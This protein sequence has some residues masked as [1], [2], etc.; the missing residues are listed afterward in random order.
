VLADGRVALGHRRLS[1]I[2]LSDEAKQP[3][4]SG[5]DSLTVVFN[6][7]IYNFI[8]LRTELRGLGHIFRTSSDTEIILAAYRQW[9]EECFAKFNGM[10]ALALWDNQFKRLVLSRDRFGKKPLYYRLL[11]NRLEFASEIKALAAADGLGLK[12]NLSKVARYV[13]GNYRYV[14]NDT[15]SFFSGINQIPK[16]SWVSFDLQGDRREEVY[17]A[18]KVPESTSLPSSTEI[19]N[20]VDQFRDLLVDAVKIRLRSDVPVGCM[21]SG[22]MDSTS[23]TAIAHRLLKQPVLTFSGITGEDRGVYDESEYIDAVVRETGAEHHYIRP[24]PASLF[25]TLDEMLS[26]HDEPVCTVTW[27][28]LYLI[29]KKLKERRV[30]V[31]LNGHGGDEILAGYWDHY[32]YHFH[33]LLAAGRN[34]EREHE[35]LAWKQN[36]GREVSELA[37]YE[38]MIPLLLKGKMPWESRFADYRRCL[39]IGDH[40]ALGESAWPMPMPYRSSLNNRMHSELF[41]ETVPAVLRPEDRNTMS[42]SIESRSPFLDYRLAEIC[43][44]LDG[45]LKIRNG[46]GKWILREAMR[47]ILPESVRTRKDKSGFIAPADRWFREGARRDLLVLVDSESFGSRTFLDHGAIRNVVNEHVEG[48]SNHAMFLWQLVNMELWFRRFFD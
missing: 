34:E 11:P 1:I 33:D 46:L 18:L 29:S 6:G 8:E 7:E 19:R 16:S 44:S 40:P 2:D 14:D 37:R 30:P 45:S 15:E 10:W 32:H 26:F 39:R 23:I 31:V 20:S 43:F 21:L 13:A 12:P 42:Q 3:M 22:G 48:K 47:G 24:E 35:I 4:S 25:V 28:S 41:F 5:D 9:G 27:Y 38:D 17:W 36:H